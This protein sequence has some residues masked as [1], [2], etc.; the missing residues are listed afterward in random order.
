MPEYQKRV[1]EEKKE[2]SDK[3]TKLAVFIASKAFDELSSVDKFLLS[4]QIK[5]MQSYREVLRLRVSAF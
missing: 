1:I 2:L 4:E 5:H 3:V